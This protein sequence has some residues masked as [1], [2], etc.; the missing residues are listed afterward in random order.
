MV[1]PQNPHPRNVTDAVSRITAAA[2][3]LVRQLLWLIPPASQ[4]GAIAPDFYIVPID[5]LALTSR[6]QYLA[7]KGKMDISVVTLL[8]QTFNSVLMAGLPT[9]TA[10]LGNRGNVFTYDFP[11]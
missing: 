1:N 5:Q 11:S 4:T 8:S 2:Q 9:L 6:A 3:S 10:A 7:S